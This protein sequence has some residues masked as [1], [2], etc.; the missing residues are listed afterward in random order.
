MA[1]WAEVYWK[2]ALRAQSAESRCLKSWLKLIWSALYDVSKHLIL[3]RASDIA[4]SN[5]VV[6]YKF[7]LRRQRTQDV[8]AHI[9][10]GNIT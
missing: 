1:A 8:A 4:F 5:Q 3:T 6:S 10:F 7:L 9:H 2:V